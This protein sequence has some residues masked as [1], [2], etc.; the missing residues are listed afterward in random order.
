MAR[1]NAG[2]I[3]VEFDAKTTDIRKAEATVDR[4]A[5]RMEADFDGVERKSSSLTQ[6]IGKLRSGTGLLGRAGLGVSAAFAGAALAVGKL[7]AKIAEATA[8]N[9]E[10]VRSARLLGGNLYDFQLFGQ[11]GRVLGTDFRDI[12]D[13]VL[14]LNESLNEA[15]INLGGYA[16]AW[17]RLGV[18]FR[19]VSRL[20]PID[21]LESVSTTIAQ[22]I[23][24]GRYDRG[25]A[26]QSL[27]EA[28]LNEQRVLSVVTEFTELQEQLAEWRRA[29]GEAVQATADVRMGFLR[30]AN[31][32]EVSLTEA[33]ARSAGEFNDVSDFLA[34]HTT[35]IATAI[36]A[37]VAALGWAAEKA[38]EFANR[39]FPG[40]IDPTHQA[41]FLREIGDYRKLSRSELERLL[42]ETITRRSANQDALEAAQRRTTPTATGGPATG[43]FAAL[44]RFALDLT[45]I[46]GPS[47]AE[48]AI[49]KVDVERL[50][51]KIRLDAARIARIEGLLAEDRSTTITGGAGGDAEQSNRDFRDFL[52]NLEAQFATRARDRDLFEW[53][54]GL[55]DRY[56]AR[57]GG[58]ATRTIGLDPF[59]TDPDSITEF[60]LEFNQ[61]VAEATKSVKVHDMILVN[62]AQ[63]VG[64]SLGGFVDAVTDETVSFRDAMSNFLRS[65]SRAITSGVGASLTD[66]ILQGIG[67][68]ASGG[69]AAGLTLVGEQGPEL[70]DFRSP[71]QVYSTQKLG[72]ALQGGGGGGGFVFSPTINNPYDAAGVGAIIEG[73]RAEFFEMVD[74]RIIHKSGYSNS[75]SQSIGRPT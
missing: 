65:L 34:S 52:R 7:S 61:A 28:G 42:G 53:G 22:G 18:N 64:D 60:Y 39:F 26:I 59:T 67:L 51:T 32:L 17:T 45:K 73:Q 56:Y 9:D 43:G 50:E 12:S 57:G 13:A 75:L 21:A 2:S 58:P 37:L 14:D 31:D 5:K 74:A 49:V 6:T 38:T 41:D 46:A 44:Q 29:S 68:R 35:N 25:T 69:Y 48:E 15:R 71:A 55:L 3:A 62:F 66:R 24:S 11:I 36:T 30:V 72:M 19:E 63:A 20:A 23:A 27:R 16:D 40:I 8:R 70:V 54:E 47:A 10:L 33:I 1:R 4:A